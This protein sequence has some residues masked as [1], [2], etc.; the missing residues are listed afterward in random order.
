MRQTSI[1][2]INNL[3]FP[4]DPGEIVYGSRSA[5]SDSHWTAVKWR[6]H[7]TKLALATGF[8]ERTQL[9]DFF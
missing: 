4:D 3:R 6:G 9:N 1:I 5:P 2:N 8:V 7:V